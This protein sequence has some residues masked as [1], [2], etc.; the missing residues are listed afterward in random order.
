MCSVRHSLWQ[1]V[2]RSTDPSA[3]TL[4]LQRLQ[5]DTAR[6]TAAPLTESQAATLQTIQG[7]TRHP[8]QSELLAKARDRLMSA[9]L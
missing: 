3:G 2:K 5:R 8:A 1:N 6:K 7:L 4:D 9:L